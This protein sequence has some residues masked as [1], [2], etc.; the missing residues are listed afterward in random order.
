MAASFVTA[1]SGNFI[2]ALGLVSTV[3]LFFTKQFLL[4]DRVK[5]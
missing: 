3:D 1:C 5:K 4:T 2:A